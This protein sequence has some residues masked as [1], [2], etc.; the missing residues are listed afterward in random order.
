MIH[1]RRERRRKVDAEGSNREK[2]MGR[3]R[4]NALGRD[5]VV[6]VVHVVVQPA[7]RPLGV[8]SRSA[9]A[10]AVEPSAKCR[11]LLRWSA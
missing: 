7:T 9:K 1:S 5:A 6:P 11:Q 4:V 8:L 3:F 10:T 2:N